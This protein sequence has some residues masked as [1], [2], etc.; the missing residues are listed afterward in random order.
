M[1][2]SA[3]PVPRPRSSSAAE[4]SRWLDG[5]LVGWRHRVAQSPRVRRLYA[6]DIDNPRQY[7]YSAM[8]VEILRDSLSLYTA[9]AVRRARDPSAQVLTA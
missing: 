5:W 3:G 6:L 8:E 4:A 2:R 1:W 9:D 7:V